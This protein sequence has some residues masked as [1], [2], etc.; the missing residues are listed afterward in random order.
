MFFYVR[1]NATATSRIVNKTTPLIS[2]TRIISFICHHREVLFAPWSLH[3]D[4]G[5]LQ[6]QP[7]TPVASGCSTAICL[8]R[9]RTRHLTNPTRTVNAPEPIGSTV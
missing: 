1:K 4:I 2:K 7:T 3:A 5:A 9:S 6:Q 8:S